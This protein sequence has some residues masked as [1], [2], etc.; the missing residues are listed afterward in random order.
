M[1]FRSKIGI[2]DIHERRPR[3][4][5][6]RIH[7][8]VPRSATAIRPQLRDPPLIEF[9]LAAV[10]R[11]LDVPPNEEIQVRALG[12]AID[13]PGRL[14]APEDLGEGVGLGRIVEIFRSEL[15]DPLLDQLPHLTGLTRE[16]PLPAALLLGIGE[17]GAA[18]CQR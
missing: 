7:S 10:D 2:R 9:G 15:G 13:L 4:R 12:V 11:L 17:I 3:G 8:T 5:L 18:S 16:M 1:D 6:F 14:T